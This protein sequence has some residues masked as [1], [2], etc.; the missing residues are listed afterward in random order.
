MSY[1]GLVEKGSTLDL[2][3]AAL[4]VLYYTW[5]L[6]LTP[7]APLRPLTMMATAGAMASSI[8]LAYQL[9]FVLGDLCILCWSTHV[10]NTLLFIKFV[11]LPLTS[12][13]TTTGSSST[14]HKVKT[15]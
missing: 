12:T 9:T 11:V 3:N 15:V 1:A 2:P 14:H 13:S 6:L 8:W 5:H 7:I 4:G 10:I